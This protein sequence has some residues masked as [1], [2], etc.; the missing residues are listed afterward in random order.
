MVHLLVHL[1]IL[2]VRSASFWK[3]R[4]SDLA[5]LLN[6]YIAQGA[7]Q[8]GGNAWL[9]PWNRDIFRQFIQD[10]SPVFDSVTILFFNLRRV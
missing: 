1:S 4:S 7:Q 9:R 8:G 2:G 3:D 10:G 6:S 5:F